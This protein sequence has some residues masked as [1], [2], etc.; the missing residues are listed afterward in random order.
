MVRNDPASSKT[1]KSNRPFEPELVWPNP[2]TTAS[3]FYKRRPNSQGEGT[4]FQKG[5]RLGGNTFISFC[6]FRVL[7][8][9]SW[10]VYSGFLFLVGSGENRERGANTVLPF[11]FFVIEAEDSQPNKGIRK[12]ANQ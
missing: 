7:F 2:D 4:A 3:F 12:L 5:K 10:S 11:S 9:S 8:F 1:T 6:Q